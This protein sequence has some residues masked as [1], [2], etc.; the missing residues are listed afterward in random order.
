MKKKIFSAVALFL[1]LCAFA[2]CGSGATAKT[3]NGMKLLT[4]GMSYTKAAK[5]EALPNATLDFAY[6]GGHDVMPIGVFNGPSYYGDN[7]SWSN[8]VIT[9][10]SSYYDG[11]YFTLLKNAGINH[12]GTF[13]NMYMNDP[14]V[15]I[16]NMDMAY[17]HGLGSFMWDNYL[18]QNPTPEAIGARIR[19]YID[20]PGLM[21]WH[22]LDEPWMNAL[23]PLKPLYDSYASLESPETE[24]K[25]LFVNLFP[26]YVVSEAL[27]Y[28]TWEEYLRTF[29]ETTH[30]KLIC[31]DHYVFSA[32]DNNGTMG[33]AS[34]FRDL[35]TAGKVAKEF[36][37]PFWVY[38]QTGAQWDYPQETVAVWPSEAEFL[39]NVNTSVGYGAKGIQYFQGV[40]WISNALEPDG[41]VNSER[42]GFIG[43][44]GNVNR[45]YYYAQK[46]HKQL[47]AADEILMNSALAGVITVGEIA[48]SN[49]ADNAKYFDANFQEG[50]WRELKSVNAKEVLVSCF[51]YCGTSAFWVVNNSAFEKDIVKLNF[52]KEYGCDIIQRGQN[53]PVAAKT[54][55]LNLEPGEAA[56]VTLRTA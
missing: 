7:S 23:P 42:L 22:V 33:K 52:D 41:G 9:Q 2:S 31:Y 25:H 24:G 35:L 19:E 10:P 43:V 29:M 12:I 46:A 34:Y 51:D 11:Y 56:L 21:G 17:R 54:V 15:F 4:E 20:H 16:D 40:Q 48:K 45:W 36:G 6:L 3:D 32:K 37:V 44:Q 30:S 13:D 27:D 18:Y 39:W 49:N 50:N 14:Q 47:I 5:H 53:F 28:K 55:V 8:G 1:A 26:G 38:V